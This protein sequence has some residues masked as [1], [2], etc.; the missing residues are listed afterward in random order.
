MVQMLPS[1]NIHRISNSLQGIVA[2]TFND[3]D[4][5]RMEKQPLGEGSRSKG[6][7]GEVFEVHYLHF[8]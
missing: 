2:F 1:R 8:F 5:A 6:V 4:V 7:I 3:H